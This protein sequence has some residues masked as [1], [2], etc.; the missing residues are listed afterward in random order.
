MGMKHADL[1]RHVFGTFI[2]L[3]LVSM[4]AKCDENELQKAAFEI[5]VAPDWRGIPFPND[6][7]TGAKLIDTLSRYTNY[8]PAD[9][10]KLVMML[11]DAGGDP[12]DLEV[13][14]KIYIF[15][16]L[17]CNVPESSKRDDWKIFGGWGGIAVDG[18]TVNSMYPLVLSNGKFNL[19]QFS[20][21]A[22]PPYQALEEFDWL[23]KRFGQ[24]FKAKEASP[25]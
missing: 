2:C 15:N 7:T 17:Y 12:P 13:G 6:G 9:A 10:R 14:G 16:R 5:S 23:F 21:Y 4:P 18:N 22:G 24:R 1:L 3:L 20:G 11:I 8:S 25:E 19:K